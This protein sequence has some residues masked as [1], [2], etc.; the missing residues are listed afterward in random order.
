M[1]HSAHAPARGVI[2]DYLH[3]WLEVML[4]SID[5]RTSRQHYAHV[6]RFLW[7]TKITHACQLDYRTIQSYVAY[8]NTQGYAP[9]T[10]H[11]HFFAISNLAKYLKNL[12]VVERN[13]CTDVRLPKIQK[14]IVDYLTPEEVK[15]TLALAEYC[16]IR[17]KVRTALFTGLRRAE[18][19]R[20]RFED[21]H[22]TNRVLVVK[23]KGNKLRTIPLHEKLAGDL[24][25]LQRRLNR[26]GYVWLTNRGTPTHVNHWT[27][28][29]RP[30]QQLMPQITGWH[31][32]RHTFG[33]ILAQQG[34]SITKIAS[35]LGHTK[36]QLTKDFY[37]NLAPERYD[38]D[39]LRLNLDE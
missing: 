39:I 36:E 10:V 3:A 29:L 35:W 23:G 34:C 20:L 19:A 6:K 30:L 27:H 13:P 22:F 28:A 37:V 15:E 16:G 31:I 7:H 32:F 1:L 38:E 18:L 33:S 12:G 4:A 11:K 21:I 8:L 24:Q 26:P 14:T 5:G 17:L 9:S 25:I 2:R